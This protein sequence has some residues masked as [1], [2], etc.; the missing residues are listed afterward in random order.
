MNCGNCGGSMRLEEG[1]N[2][3]ICDFC[4]NIY[5]PEATDEG[6]RVL[7]EQDSQL[8]PV[9]AIPLVNAVIGG[10][11]ILYCSRCHGMLI[12]MDDFLELVQR[13]RAERDG[14]PCETMPAP[15]PKDLDRR[16]RCPRCSQEMETH[17]YGG[18]G[19][20]VID[21]CEACGVNWLD[22]G[23]LQRI[24]RAPDQ[25]YPEDIRVAH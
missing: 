13:L 8:C 18:P 25:E 21:S 9:C 23:E 20:I 2:Y 5:F 19:N 6:V 7:D 16:I 10:L 24:V 11:R 12:P 4:R 3:L 1:K 17:P 15:D 14:A 22:H